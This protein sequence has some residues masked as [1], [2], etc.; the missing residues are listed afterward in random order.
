MLIQSVIV[1]SLFDVTVKV[2]L[3]LTVKFK[4]KPLKFVPEIMDH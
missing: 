2:A 4:P 1:K 3:L